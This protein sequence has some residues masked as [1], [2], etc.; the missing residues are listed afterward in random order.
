MERRKTRLGSNKSAFR[1]L[2]RGICGQGTALPGTWL[3]C[4]TTVS[5]RS[6]VPRPA[7]SVAEPRIGPGREP[8][9]SESE[10][11]RPGPIRS[12]EHTSDSSH[13]IISY[14]VFCL[15]KKKNQTRHQQVQ[16]E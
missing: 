8:S 16:P 6:P 3:P 11:S 4:G 10:G 14:A 2:H 13:Q 5:R 12:E 1:T 9:A 7:T 15:K